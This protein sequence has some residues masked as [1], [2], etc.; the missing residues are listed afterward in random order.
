MYDD[1]GNNGGGWSWL[2]WL[3]FLLII[4]TD[5]LFFAGLIIVPHDDYEGLIAMMVWFY[6]TLILW[7][8]Y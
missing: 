3:F 8:V 1:D 4:A 7:C 6:G 5:I 2:D